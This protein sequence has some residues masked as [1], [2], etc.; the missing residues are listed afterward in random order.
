MLICTLVNCYGSDETVLLMTAAAKAALV[1]SPRVEAGAGAA[2][3]E[4]GVDEEEEAETEVTAGED[5]E[6]V[7]TEVIAEDETVDGAAKRQV[8]RDRWTIA[9]C[10]DG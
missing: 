3:T 2:E 9:E 6:E 5:E 7:V 4:A 1:E 8:V 10:K